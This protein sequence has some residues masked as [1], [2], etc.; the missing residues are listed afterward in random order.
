MNEHVDVLIVGTG[1]GGISAAL[2]LQTLKKGSFLMLE[3]RS[4]YGGTWMQNRYPGA[5]VDVQSPLYSLEDEP[6][7]WTQMFAGQDE[8]Q[9]YTQHIVNKHGLEAHIRLNCEVVSAVWDEQKSEWLVSVKTDQIENQITCKVMI[10]A[11]GPLSTP[12]IPKFTHS[13][14]Y[15]GLIIHSND[16]PQNLD[17]R[18]K[19]ISIIGSGA[20]AVQIIPAIIDQVKQLNVFQRTPHW[21]LPR[22]DHV[23]SGFQRKLLKNKRIYQSIKTIIYAFLEL[24]VIGFKYSNTMLNVVAGRPARK[25]LKSQIGDD[26]LRQELTPDFTIGCKRVLLSNQYYPALQKSNCVL[27]TKEDGLTAFF[28]HGIETSK[29]HYVYAD[30]V[31]LATGYRA[32]DSMVSYP[33]RGRNNIE[34]NQQWEAFPRAY[35]GTSL[36][37]FPNFFVVTGPNTG[38]GHTSAIY[39]IE[40]QMRYI[41]TC[42]NKILDKQCLSIEPTTEAEKRY[43]DKVHKDMQ[44]TVWV[45]GGCN[46]WYQNDSGKVIAMFPGFSFVF[47]QLCKKWIKTDHLIKT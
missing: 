42:V 44:R 6:Y 40:S 2:K 31:I 1:F 21:V 22:A 7:D 14:K 17:I 47:R 25:H 37:N 10:N 13:D 35:L 27:H 24:R 18:G 20:S 30:I 41:L 12:S 38:I 16:W 3:R 43:T 28:E 36:P 39:V 9:A 45:T 5:A 15:K 33:V 8:L 4:F 11:T 29:G 34:L 23:F 32:S 19:K 46:S 26:N